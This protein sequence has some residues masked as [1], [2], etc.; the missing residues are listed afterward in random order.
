MVAMRWI[1]V[2]AGVLLVASVLAGSEEQAA[3]EQSPLIYTL[4]VNGLPYTIGLGELVTLPAQKGPLKV[5]LRVEP[6]RVVR[7]QGV[8]FRFPRG[9]QLKRDGKSESWTLRM[10]RFRLSIW[11]GRGERDAA[12]VVER[13]IEA[14]VE[15]VRNM[16]YAGIASKVIRTDRLLRLAGNKVAGT[17]FY[18]GLDGLI[19]SVHTFYALRTGPDTVLFVFS[20]QRKDGLPGEPSKEWKEMERLLQKSLKVLPPTDK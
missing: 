2:A 10:R 13:R 4:E 12:N 8:E 5:R 18:E 11:I 19:G 14:M 1:A 20:E 16:P 15:L 9:W 17:T 6:Y 7:A 3:E